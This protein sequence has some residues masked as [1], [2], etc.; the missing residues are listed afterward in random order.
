MKDPPEL[1]YDAVCLANAFKKKGNLGTHFNWKDLGI[2][3]GLCFNSL[4]SNVNFLNGPLQGVHLTE[5]DEKE[6]NE[7]VRGLEGEFI[8]IDILD[9]GNIDSKNDNDSDYLDEVIIYEGSGSEDSLKDCV[10]ENV[11]VREEKKRKRI[12]HEGGR[13][14][15]GSIDRTDEN[16][17]SV[18]GETDNNVEVLLK[19]KV[20]TVQDLFTR[21]RKNIKV[22]GISYSSGIAI[23]TRRN[24]KIIEYKKVYRCLMVMNKRNKKEGWRILASHRDT[25]NTD[26]VGCEG[27]MEGFFLKDRY[28]F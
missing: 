3:V 25:S 17:E 27:R 19:G 28:W 26:Y 10:E 24:K 12:V 2:Q 7:V 1:Y 13:K 6:E 22:D 16:K 4:P 5:N 21:E 8:D 18:K 11:A 14:K 15:T 20:A 9:E 23:E